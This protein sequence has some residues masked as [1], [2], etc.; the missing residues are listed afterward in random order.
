MKDPILFVSPPPHL[1]TDIT[2]KKIMCDVIIALVPALFVSLYFFRFFALKTIIVSLVS[3]ILTEFII[4]RLFYKD[5]TIDNLSAIVTGLLLA[6]TL[7]P[8]LPWWM[9]VIG[10][11]SAIAI[12][13]ELFGGLGKNIFNPALVG[14]AILFA[15]WP[16]AMTSWISPIDGV[17]CATPL[18]LKK[19]GIIAGLPS[20]WELFI[21]NRAGSI[22]ETSTIALLIGGIYLLLRKTITWH[23]PFSFICIVFLGGVILGNNP[24]FEIMSGGIFLGA[25][26]MATDYVTSPATAKG[27]IIFGIA[28]GII[29]MLIRY[30]GGFS[31][32]VCYAILIMNMLTPLIEMATKPRPFGY[33]KR[34]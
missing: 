17:S 4:R 18:A 23:I 19:I 14:R 31:E 16:E 9:V 34:R 10:G 25:L 22:G 21:G 27:K 30:F 12:G 6:F 24:F 7:P 3:C 2:I 26:F 32:G 20:L 1:H 15:S 29:T 8:P 33:I 11:I 5:R 13:K 28:C